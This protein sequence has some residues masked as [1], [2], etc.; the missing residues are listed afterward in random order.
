MTSDFSF[1]FDFVIS[2]VTSGKAY[3]ISESE[4]PFDYKVVT[5]IYNNLWG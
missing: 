5:Y 4:W 2:D 1:I 3:K